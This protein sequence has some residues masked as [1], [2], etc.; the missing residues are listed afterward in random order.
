MKDIKKVVAQLQKEGAEIIKDVIVK[1]VT[2]SNQ[3]EWTRVVLTLNKNVPAMVANDKGDY[4]EGERNIIFTS[5]FS[6]GA[7]LS[8]NEDIAFAKNLVMQTPELLTMVLSY[9]N[10][11]V[12][13]E[14]VAKGTE[15]TNPFSDKA[16]SRIVEHDSIYH[17]VVDLNLGKK[18]QKLTGMLESKVLDAMIS[19]AFTKVVAGT[20]PSDDNEEE[21]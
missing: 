12:V 8:N 5:T 18:G 13:A 6:I 19:G 17:H 16:G 1:N 15:Y 10:V 11:T 9:A 21:A 2:V 20:K 7:L 4:V 14:H 3:D